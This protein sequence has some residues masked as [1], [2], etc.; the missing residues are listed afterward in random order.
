[1]AMP[2]NLPPPEALDS[3]PR[4]MPDGSMDWHWFYEQVAVLEAWARANICIRCGKRERRNGTAVCDTAECEGIG[5]TERTGRCVFCGGTR[6]L[7]S[8]WADRLCLSFWSAATTAVDAR[9]LRVTAPLDRRGCS[10]GMESR[11]GRPIISYASQRVG[12]R[13]GVE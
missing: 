8:S 7:Y 5:I 6:K 3:E 1:M 12:G 11:V 13:T 2:D 4:L 9:C 10:D